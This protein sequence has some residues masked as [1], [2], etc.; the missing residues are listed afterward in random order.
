VGSLSGVKELTEETLAEVHHPAAE[1]VLGAILDT[2]RSF[3]DKWNGARTPSW[4]W[5]RPWPTRGDYGDWSTHGR[6]REASLPEFFK[7]LGELR[8]RIRTFVGMLTDLESKAVA[9]RLRSGADES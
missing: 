8:S 3:L 1:A 9:P 6:A 5:D 2:L 4:E 7:D